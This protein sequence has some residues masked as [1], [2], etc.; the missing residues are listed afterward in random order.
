MNCLRVLKSNVTFPW[1]EET[2]P[3]IVCKVYH[4][5][6]SYIA[7][8]SVV[9]SNIKVKRYPNIKMPRD[10]MFE[11]IYL[12]ALKDKVSNLREYILKEL[13][14]IYPEDWTLSEFVEK[15]FEKLKKNLAARK[16]RFRRKAYLN[17]WNYF[18]TLTYDDNKCDED[19]FAKSL[20]R[21]LSN[22]HTRKGWLYMGVFE[23][24]PESGRLHFHGL[25][26]IPEDKMLGTIKEVKDYSTKRRKV[27]I[28]HI[29]TFFADRFGRNDFEALSDAAL[30][31][32]NTI[33]YLLKYL[34][35]TDERI[36][37]SRGIPTEFFKQIT[38][39]DIC[40]EMLD[41]VIKYVLFDDVI[42]YESDVLYRHSSISDID[43]IQTSFL[44]S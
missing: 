40:C 3:N 5:G 30:K 20:R 35:K 39:D 44:P 18:V 31:S 16:K 25:F 27:Q 42:D 9:D 15:K 24:A 13:S 10:D 36:I 11:Q 37:Y 4:D 29:N 19:T 6:G 2:R 1:F 32:G 43:Y 26:N 34:E 38:D 28:T 8:P 12:Q 7:I 41:F 17:K 33:N 21:C 14:G 23:R 22:L